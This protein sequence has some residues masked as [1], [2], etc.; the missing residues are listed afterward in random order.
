MDY[1]GI[2]FGMWSNPEFQA[3]LWIVEF[4]I[5]LLVYLGSNPPLTMPECIGMLELGTQ[6]N[7]RFHGFG[8]WNVA[9]FP[10]PIPEIWNLECG[11]VSLRMCLSI[12]KCVETL[13]SGIDWVQWIKFGYLWE[14]IDRHRPALPHFQPP[15]ERLYMCVAT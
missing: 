13:E 8:I 14:E 15:V 3:W 10:I 11:I 5:A 9:E 1:N 6:M 7:S 12:P 4:E 2:E